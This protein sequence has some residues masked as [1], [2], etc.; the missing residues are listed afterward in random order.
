[1]P[2]MYTLLAEFQALRAMLANEDADPQTVADTLESL[3]GDIE[4]KMLQLGRIWRELEADADAT[5]AEVKRLAERA[6]ARHK[7]ADSL[8]TFIRTAMLTAHVDVAKDAAVTVRLQVGPPSVEVLDADQ[9][10]SDYK[11][12]TLTMLLPDVPE[13]LVGLA[14]VEIDRRAILDAHKAGADVAG[15]RVVRNQFLRIS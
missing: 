5:D 1:M 7:R 9:V 6:N 10:P 8:K 13:D 15:T 4:T 2:A 12:A 3:T 14:K 11:R